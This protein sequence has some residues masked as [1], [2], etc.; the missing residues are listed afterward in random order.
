MITQCQS[1]HNKLIEEEISFL[2]VADNVES[3]ADKTGICFWCNVRRGNWAWTFILRV[4]NFRDNKEIEE[5]FFESFKTW[6]SSQY[7]CQNISVCWHHNFIMK[8]KSFIDCDDHE[9]STFSELS[10]SIAEA[11]E[12]GG[13]MLNSLLKI[14]SSSWGKVKSCWILFRIDWI[15]SIFL[16]A[17]PELAVEISCK[18]SRDVA[19]RDIR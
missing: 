19:S 1:I 18:Q 8:T 10:S 15:F 9:Y 6:R 5:M 17:S 3:F 4:D 2:S 11:Q 7:C 13:V 12:E 14:N 16:I